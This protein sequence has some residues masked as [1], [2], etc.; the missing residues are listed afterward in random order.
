MCPFPSWSSCW[1]SPPLVSRAGD[2]TVLPLFAPK[3]LSSGAL[4]KGFEL[5]RGIQVPV[6][7]AELG[8][9]TSLSDNKGQ[10][11]T[12]RCRWTLIQSRV[13]KGLHLFDACFR[14][15]KK[16]G[17]SVENNDI[18]RPHGPHDPLATPVS[19]RLYLVRHQY[20][21]S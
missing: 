5:G 21:R 1:T 16:D 12:C 14:P 19:P 6:K 3:W 18:P 13:F 20:T 7:S 11:P 17:R 4:R 10:K 9:I 15:V 8:R 2:A